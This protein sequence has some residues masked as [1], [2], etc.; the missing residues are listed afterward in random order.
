LSSLAAHPERAE[1]QG[2]PR[3]LLITQT[4]ENNE[5][6]EALLVCKQG[7]QLAKHHDRKLLDD[8]AYDIKCRKE[9]LANPYSLPGHF[10][11][12]DVSLDDECTA[13]D[14]P[15]TYELELRT[16]DMLNVSRNKQGFEVSD[17]D[18]TTLLHCYS[19]SL[20]HTYR[21]LFRKQKTISMYV[22]VSVRGQDILLTALRPRD[23][24]V[25]EGIDW[26]TL[27]EV[28]G[29]Y[30]ADRLD[31]FKTSV[32]ITTAIKQSVVPCLSFP[33]T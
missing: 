15:I 7:D 9:R 21:E 32:Q 12:M 6:R 1:W 29:T 27:P 8:P 17:L 14:E 5:H 23:L 2:A 19:V 26:M 31:V 30:S 28:L 13:A 24:S 3:H 11:A 33:E 25:I 10:L 22:C 16:A 4:S 18:D 20:P